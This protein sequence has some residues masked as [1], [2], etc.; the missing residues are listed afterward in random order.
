MQIYVTDPNFI[1]VTN[2]L[3]NSGISYFVG[4]GTLLRLHR[5]GSLSPETTDID[6]CFREGSVDL[7]LLATL[8]LQLGFEME[9]CDPRN[10]QFVREGGRKIDLNFFTYHLRST[11]DGSCL[12]HDVITWTVVPR[13]TWL[14]NL[15]FNLRRITNVIVGG[16]SPE[17]R[18]KRLLANFISPILKPL[19][20][21]FVL[22]ERKLAN[23][24]E[25]NVEYRIPSHLL[26]THLVS[27]INASWYQPV[28][29]ETVLESL[30]GPNWRTP[31]RRDEWFGFA[32]ESPKDLPLASKSL[33]RLED[34]E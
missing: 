30:Y 13:G 22:I 20:T 28:M 12:S 26:D 25:R 14:S 3:N 29:V 18:F 31:M 17:N 2:A 10:M 4:G 8:V 16:N 27:T 23:E 1:D 9:Y 11:P 15:Y 32:K 6:I 34:N 24:V 33:G 19:S 7:A 21:Y 5:D